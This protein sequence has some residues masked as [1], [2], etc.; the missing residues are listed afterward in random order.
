MMPRAEEILRTTSLARFVPAEHFERMRDRF[1]EVHYDFGETIIRQG[2]EADAF[3]V[4]ITGRARVLKEQPDGEEITLHRLQPGHEFGESALLEEKTRTT[5]V[6]CSTAVDVLRL[7]RKDFQELV[8]EFPELLNSLEL[9]SRWR[10]LHSFLYTYSHFGRLSAPALRAL[11]DHLQP[12]DFKQGET[13]IRQG[14]PAGPMFIVREGRVRIFTGPSDKAVNVAFFRE[15]D[16]FGELS[17]M[18]GAPRAA[19]AE[20]ASDCRLLALAPENVAILDR[21]FPEIE[22]LLAERRALYQAKVKTRVPLD[23]S[24]ELLPAEAETPGAAKSAP[25]PAEDGVEE[26]FADERGFFRR[27][28]GRIRRM[29]IVLQIDEMDC[30]AACLAM[31]C[32]HFGRAVNIARIREL[33]H[34]SSDGTSLDGICSAASELGLAARGIKASRKHL[35]QMPLPAIAHWEGRHW[36]VIYHVSDT[37]VWLADPA[38][39]RR[40]VTR[41]EFSELWSGYVALFDYTVAFEKAPVGHSS[42]AWLVPFF[43]RH[44]GIFLQALLLAL[45]VSGLQLILPIATQ[46]VVD[47]VIVDQEMDLLRQVVFGMAAALVGLVACNLLQQYLLSFATVRVDCSILDYLTRRMLELPMSYFNSRRTGDIQRRLEGARE[48]REFIVQHGIG[49]LLA[50]IQFAGC[51]GLMVLYSPALTGVFLSMLPLYA[52]LMWF[53]QRVLRP[54]FAELE[55]NHAR[56]SS[57]QI[58]AIKGIEAVKASAAEPAFREALLSQ[59]L[60]VSKGLLRGSFIMMTYQSA[61]QVIGLLSGGLFLWFGA[62]QVVGGELTVGRFVA[63]NT[64]LAMAA[65]AILRTLG[66][67]DHLQWMTVLL[68]RL[69]DIFEAEPEQG[70]DHSHLKPVRSLEGQIEFRNVGFRYGG[71]ESMPILSGINLRVAPGKTVA[72]VGRSGSGKTTLIKLLAGLIQPTEGSILFDNVDIRTVSLRDLRCRIGIVLQE[73]YTFADTILRNVAFGDREPDFERVLRATQL[74]NAHDFISRLPLGYETRIGETG[75]ALS[76]GQRQ[77]I[78]IARALYR[79]PPVLIFDEATSALDTESERAI[80][81]NLRQLLHDRTSFVIAHRLSTVRDA[82]VIL[83]LERGRIVETG[84]HDEL[85]KARGLYFHLCSQQ[86]SL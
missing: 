69:S 42:W 65:A 9:L 27:R 55:A 31:I 57:Y 67:W 56:Y 6:R 51:L 53:S 10:A 45:A 59:F 72:I 37:H 18:T 28:T 71:P 25:S 30:G 46:V 68:N 17:V 52:G 1:E 50:V 19:S 84:T 24:Q 16:Y 33:C 62:R 78:A 77:R 15:G 64:L 41:T 12:V 36:L 83:V 63:F 66:V 70:R 47:R 4:L 75:L 49:S 74:A 79:D 86:L 39:G 11:I 35:G 82:D 7:G 85:M 38:V 3:F 60:G 29:P 14:D 58:D 5:T 8:E 13:I 48:I 40:K 76:G 43:T 26:P 2:E 81:D 54:L 22:K 73:N 21:Q 20:A 23:F 44:Q 32:R 61:I 34:V 80:Q